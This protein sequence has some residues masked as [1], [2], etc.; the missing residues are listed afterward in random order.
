M[1]YNNKKV[2]RDIHGRTLS[3]RPSTLFCDKRCS[4]F[5]YVLLAHWFNKGVK[6]DIPQSDLVLSGDTAQTITGNDG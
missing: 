3:K 4:G 2:G 1:R 6:R 5:L